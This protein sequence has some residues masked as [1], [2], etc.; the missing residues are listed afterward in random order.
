MKTKLLIPVLLLLSLGAAA[1]TS[2]K[3]I[4]KDINRTGGSYFAYPGP[5]QKALTPAPAGY[6]PFYISHYSRH[7]SRYMLDNVC[8]VYSIE[9]LDTAAQLGI[10]SKKGA[11]VLEI[12]RAGYADALKRDGDLTKLGGRQH[13]EIA[14]RMYDRFPELLSQPLKVDARSSTV[15]R[16]MVSMFNFCQELQGL[17]PSLDIRMD[18]SR[19]DMRFIVEDDHMKVEDTPRNQGISDRVNRMYEKAFNPSHLMKLLFTN[20]RKAESFVDGVMLMDC[21]NNVAEDFQNVPEL[22]LSLKDIFTKDELFAIWNYYNS[23]WIHYCGIIPGSTPKYKCKMEVRDTI[24]SIADRVIRNGEPTVTLRFSHDGTVMPLTYML[25]FKEVMGAATNVENLY[26]TISIDRIIPMAAN[27]Q[28]VFYRK[29]GSDDVLVK[30]LLNENET[31][32]PEVKSDVAPYYHWA[33]VKRYWDS[34]GTTLMNR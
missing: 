4:L 8:Y 16:C 27:I 25:G 15:G 17:N 34:R 22:G 18:A 7:G 2:K 28:M 6:E 21:L 14:H 26:K 11:A 10:L 13:R 9:K 29:E 3:E 31:S 12:L 32:L 33:D 20:V 5:T 24:I 1:Q 30:F 23:R 19:G